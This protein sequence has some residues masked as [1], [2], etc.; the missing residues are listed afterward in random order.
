MK[1][2]P[3]GGECAVEGCEATHSSCWYG[4]K[5]N[6]TCRACY[7]RLNQRKISE[8]IAATTIGR[9]RAMLEPPAEDAPVMSAADARANIKEI[10]K[11]QA[12]RF[13]D[14]SKASEPADLREP[15]EADERVRRPAAHGSDS[16]RASHARSDAPRLTACTGARVQ[17]VTPIKKT[18]HFRDGVF[19]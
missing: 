15:L 7:G 1:P 10:F 2:H 12:Q 14:L 13:W 11:I 8:P 19:S 3:D 5:G 16:R 9:K 6:K 18:G 4:K 17:S